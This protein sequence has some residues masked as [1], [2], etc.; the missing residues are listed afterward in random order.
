MHKQ[1]AASNREVSM[2]LKVIF[3]ATF[4]IGLDLLAFQASAQQ[5]CRPI[6]IYPSTAELVS[7]KGLADSIGCLAGRLPEDSAALQPSDIETLGQIVILA[8]KIIGN[9]YSSPVT[10]SH[11]TKMEQASVV[12]PS[13][14]AVAGN[15]GPLQVQV[16]DVMSKVTKSRSTAA[17]PT[18]A[19]N[20]VLILIAA[21]AMLQKM[22]SS[23]STT[24]SSAAS[25]G[26]AV[27]LRVSKIIGNG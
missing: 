4:A 15:G 14:K 17:R 20:A 7:D 27:I 16:A 5:V 24:C 10:P 9:G 3:A 11:Q 12:A 23:S 25:D 18:N 26:R 21:E 22:M 6:A 2:M 1:D 13:G 8:S 19:E